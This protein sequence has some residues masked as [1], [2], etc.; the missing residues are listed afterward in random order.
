M[1]KY[2]I[3]SFSDRGEALAKKI[4]EALGCGYDRCR[5]DITLDGWTAAYFDF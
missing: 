3:L 4:A 5:G 2:R 1:N